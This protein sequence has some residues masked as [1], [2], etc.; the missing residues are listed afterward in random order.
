MLL[1]QT[2][3]AKRIVAERL[4]STLTAASGFEVQIGAIDGTLPFDAEITGVRVSDAQGLW[5][6][7]DRLAL[8]WR[9]LDLLVGRLHVTDLAAGTVTLARLPASRR[10]QPTDT[11]GIDLSL[12]L[13]QLPLPTTVD[14]LRIE[15]IVLAPTV[16]GEAAMLTLSGR[17]RLG[18]AA[19][20][21][22]VALAIARIDGR[23]GTAGLTFGQSGSPAQLTLDASIDEPAGGLIA[24]ALSLPGLPPVSLRLAGNG[25]TS[26]W[27][28][29]LQAVAGPTRLDGTLALA[30][31][32]ALSLDLGAHA[33]EAGRLA[34]GITAFVP[35]SFEIAGRLRWQPGQRLDVARLALSA[36]EATVALSGGVDLDGGSVQASV[37]VAIADASRWRTLLA[38]AS[39]RTAHLAGSLSGP[40]DQPRF[41][42]QTS[43]NDLVAPQISAARL[44]AK[45]AGNAT[46]RDRQVVTALSIAA[47]GT[48]SGIAIADA[49]L[50]GIIGNAATWSIR[51]TVDLARGAATIEQAKIV[52]GD[53]TIAAAGSVDAYGHAVSATLE[54]DINDIEPLAQA[55]KQPA[56][57]RLG[58]TA[59]LSGDAVAPRLSAAVSGNFR[60]F[61][62]GE[63]TLM[64]LLGSAPAID[65]TFVATDTTLEISALEI[66]GADGKLTADGTVGLDGA[67]LDLNLAAA[68]PDIAPLTTSLVDAAG[69]RARRQA[70]CHAYAARFAA[71][72]RGNGRPD[73]SPCARPGPSNARPNRA[74]ERRGIT[75][76]W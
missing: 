27:R 48:S 4:A 10:E 60:E 67:S 69:G 38:P 73:R 49:R 23:V 36:P 68:V 58:L 31:D 42:L 7:V 25:P 1:L 44:E 6:T 26:D 41:A 18:G 20:E 53:A 24:R 40:L 71:A 13:P 12:G 14:G 5:L 43:I 32:D 54:A 29:R 62:L 11:H 55:L 39:F 37:D 56:A 17:A 46:L 33:D 21:A 63:P 51:G 66:T 70:A 28:G 50:A 30:I 34:P 59:S 61:A 65:G 72:F 9:M 47:E 74:R 45:A 2:P 8:G 75:R 3:A 35:P 16:L 22:A 64:K 19:R 15:R 52:A 76:R 57:G